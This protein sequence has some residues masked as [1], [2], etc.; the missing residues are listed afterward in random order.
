[1]KQACHNKGGSGDGKGMREDWMDRYEFDS[2]KLARFPLPPDRAATIPWARALD[3]LGHAR[4]ADTV[5]AALADPGWSS[6]ASLRAWLQARRERDLL[7]L[8]QMVGLQEELDW[9]VYQL[10][11]LAD[12]PV[13]DPERTPPVTPG[14]RA[15]ELELARRDAAAR[16]AFARGEAPDDVPTDWFSL[17]GWTPALTLPD[18]LDAD[19]SELTDARW[20][21][22]A[23]T[24]HLQLL[25]APV[26]KR[27]WYRPDYAE[28][29][30][31]GLRAW[32]L[33]R[34]EEAVRTLGVSSP[35]TIARRLTGDARVGA[36][37]AVLT[38]AEAPDLV[39]LVAGLMAADAVAAHP[40]H[41]YTAKGLIKRRAWEKTWA[42]QAA[43]DRGEKAGKIPVPPAYTG[44]D[45]VGAVA[46][47]LRGKLDVPKERFVAH[48]EIPT[49]EGKRR[50]PED[51]LYAWAG[52][53]REE[54]LRRLFSLLED[55]DD[56]GLPAPERTA[57]HDLMFRYIEDLTRTDPA[58]AANLRTDLRGEAG[59]PPTELQVE[60]WVK[61]HPASGG[62]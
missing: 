29:E 4:A 12:L 36:A 43:E 25:E 50:A 54:R 5:A 6:P 10:Y 28:E 18:D 16:A 9:R 55:L 35:R 23:R 48:T 42:L 57:L 20:S 52:W 60:A 30:Q 40:V 8:R 2:T 24:P 38:G 41:R 13:L 37:A 33:D 11:G 44:V 34:L 1:M 26:H 21:L 45:F 61:K 7:R 58:R 51:A 39:R 22:T 32:L 14:H 46:Y 49:A 62:W 19:W 47:P 31:A 3:A 27:R 59:P 15:F 56:E 17:Q 53:T